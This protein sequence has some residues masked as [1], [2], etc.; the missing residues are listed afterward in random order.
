M[1]AQM[2]YESNSGVEV[3]K[4]LYRRRSLVDRGDAKVQAY[5]PVLFVGPGLSRG[6]DGGGRGR[7]MEKE[8]LL[9]SFTQCVG[10]STGAA[11]LLFALTGQ[12]CEH[13]NIYWVEVASKKFFSPRRML[14]GKPV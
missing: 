6:A 3:L 14:F 8:G 5:R 11:K 7:A 10:S 13:L 1:E 2:R 12:I 4:N 9:K